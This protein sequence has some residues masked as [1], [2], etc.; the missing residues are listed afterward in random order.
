MLD[1]ESQ[2][3]SF[4]N[5]TDSM[6]QHIGEGKLLWEPSQEHLSGSKVAQYMD[7]LNE[8]R[9]LNFSSYSDLW[10]WSVTDLEGFW[11]SIWDFFEINSS[12]SYSDVLSSEAMPGAQWFRGAEL[13][14]AE[15]ALRRRDNRLAVLFSSET[16]PIETITYTELYLQV[17]ATATGLRN[18][19]VGVGDRVVGIMPN[20]PETLVA[21]LATASIG[22][23]WSSCS[24]EFGISSVIER[25]RQI[26]PTVMLATDGHQYGGKYYDTMDAVGE[27]EDQLP[28]LQHVVVVPYLSEN[29]SLGRVK[30]GCLWRDLLSK[31]EEIKF[32][33][34]GFSHPLWVLYSSG[35][36]GLPKPIVHGHGGILLEHLKTLGLHM[37]I[38]EQDRLF[39]ITTTGWMMWNYLIGGLL[40]GAAVVLYDGNPAYPDMNVLWSLAQKS[41]TTYFGASAPYIQACMKAGIVPGNDF[42]LTLIKGL[43]ST[44]A[45]LSADGFM[46]VYDNV[47]SDL[48]LGSFSGGTDLCT[49]FAGPCPLLPVRAGE[50]QCR[51]LGA[52]VES[53]NSRGESVV[54]VVGELV[55]TRPMPSMPLFLWNDKDDDR[56][57]ESYFDTF[58]GIW[59]HGDWIRITS[60]GSCVITGRSDSTLNRGGVRMGTSEFYRV[61]EAMPEVEDSLVVDTAGFE[62]EGKLLLFLVLA[63]GISLD[64]ELQDRIK[65]SLRIDLSPRHIPNEIHSISEVPRTLNAKKIEVPVK[66]ILSGVR[67]EDAVSADAM[68]N[69]SSLNFFVNLAKIRQAH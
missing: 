19:G 61:V 59:R 36:T 23:I 34:V 64:D 42:D 46:W 13:N 33:Q 51:C 54:D 32:E 56:Y 15:H 18:M 29:P 12:S 30:K 28:T 49:G 21:F 47:N 1:F 25:F 8:A 41:R 44:G 67:P 3:S 26:E 63:E 20:I 53:Y 60:R 69:P 40:T 27:I 4:T 66:R 62:I 57:R 17:A 11:V 48:L 43:G 24:P 58:Q 22:A 16:R 39:W 31:S 5:D 9:G 7:W 55:I 38:G 35:T 6:K 14:Y 50:I 52:A 45:P 37:D 10:Q 2:R 68:A 65:I